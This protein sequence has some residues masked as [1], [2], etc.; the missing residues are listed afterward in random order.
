MIFKVRPP[1]DHN[2]YSAFA[3]HIE[4]DAVV[5]YYP[6]TKDGRSL[7]I[8]TTDAGQMLLEGITVGDEHALG[9][10][11]VISICS[12]SA[13]D[14]DDIIKRDIVVEAGVDHTLFLSIEL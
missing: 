5:W 3:R 7:F 8:E 1:R 9:E 12:D 10:Y 6:A 14:W 13:L 11:E 4:S 2:C